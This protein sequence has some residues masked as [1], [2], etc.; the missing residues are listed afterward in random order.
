[1][2]IYKNGYLG[3]AGMVETE[4]DLDIAEMDELSYVLNE[5][6]FETYDQYLEAVDGIDEYYENESL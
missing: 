2:R 5:M 3:E 6:G 1:M 4:I